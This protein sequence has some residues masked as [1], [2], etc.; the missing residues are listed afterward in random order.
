MTVEKIKYYYYY[1]YFAIYV[2]LIAFIAIFRGKDRRKFYSKKVFKDIGLDIV[3]SGDLENDTNFLLINHQSH[4]DIFLVEA[5]S[6]K[7]LVW[8]AKKELSKIPIFGTMLKKFDTILVERENKMGLA[9]LLKDVQ[10]RIESQ[11]V[12]C[13]FP[14]G[15]RVKE[16]KLKKF[17]GGAKLIASKFDL[18][19]QPV[20]VVGSHYLLDSVEKKFRRVNPKVVFLPP[21][22][23]SNPHWYEK[24]QNDMQEVIDYEFKHN[25]CR[26]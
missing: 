6:G 11:R 25:H 20:V 19:V 17:K 14:E 10:K 24:M 23:K 21:V 16:Q 26:R 3:Q 1:I 8:I 13:I 2:L 12:V 7:N 5:V 4:L 15:T 9:K 18:K 22:D